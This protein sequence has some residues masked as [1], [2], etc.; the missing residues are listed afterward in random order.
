[1][2]P[3]RTLFATEP[4]EPSRAVLPDGL[5][6][7]YD[8]NLSFPPAPADRPY[9]I[10]N[11]VSTL[12][13]VVS[14][15]LPGQ[16][17]GAQ[18]SDSNEEDRFIMGLLRASADAVV[19]GSGTLQAAGPHGSWLPESVYP[20]AKDLY[21]SYRTEV[22]RKLEY[23][24][25][26]VVTGTGGLDL[27]SAV[28]HTPK[29]R[30]LILTTEQGK[31]R[32]SQSGSEALAS[33]EVKALS[34]AD[35]RISPSAILTLLRQEAGAE[36]LLHEAG[37]TLFGEFLAGGFMDELFLTVAPQIAGRV[38]EHPRPGLVANIQFSPATAPWWMLLSAKSAADYLFLR[39]QVRDRST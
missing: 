19:V 30:V 8:G 31:Q 7:R 4:T 23:P 5:R 37:P 38:A 27:T 34:A 18:I 2:A 11:F 13:G 39:Y 3:I 21:R 24:L 9:L 16:S 1:M 15:N 12:D 29:T 35:T 20:A 10:A 14:F 26:V 22:L 17:E 32:L 36:L 33:V 6:A 25:V 28:F